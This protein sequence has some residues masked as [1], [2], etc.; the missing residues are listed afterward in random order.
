MVGARMLYKLPRLSWSAARVRHTGVCLGGDLQIPSQRNKGT[1][2]LIH[3]LFWLQ[4]SCDYTKG[5]KGL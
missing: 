5:S 2:S 4:S 1:H 3:F